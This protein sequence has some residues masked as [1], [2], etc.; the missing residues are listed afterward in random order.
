[1]VRHWFQPE[2]STCYYC[3]DCWP[4]I[5]LIVW[6]NRINLG[7]VQSDA[8]FIAPNLI[9]SQVQECVCAWNSHLG[10][11]ERVLAGINR[12]TTRPAPWEVNVCKPV[13]VRAAKVAVQGRAT[14]FPFRQKTRSPRHVCT[15]RRRIASKM[16]SP[17]F[18][19]SA[20]DILCTHSPLS[21]W[22]AD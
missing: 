15:S 14:A 7:Q 21:K 9:S 16:H 8:V 17:L 4:T 2:K 3:P 11:F 12:G 10:Q 19:R 6:N 18:P 20:T 22:A 13:V 1:M 5:F